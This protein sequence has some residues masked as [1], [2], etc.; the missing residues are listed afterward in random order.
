MNVNEIFKR[1]FFNSA[2]DVQGTAWRVLQ[3]HLVIE[4]NLDTEIE[5]F[6]PMGS[7]YLQRVS[8]SFKHKLELVAS[9][10]RIEE[11]LINA[12][13]EL[14]RVRNKVA[15]RF[16]YSIKLEDVDPIGTAFGQLI[17]KV[18]PNLLYADLKTYSGFSKSDLFQQVDTVL[19]EKFIVM[20]ELSEVD[21][22][23]TA[24]ERLLEFLLTRL[25]ILWGNAEEQL[26][27]QQSAQP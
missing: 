27:L 20:R 7:V 11:E 25:L 12:T 1:F 18:T 5:A 24:P 16:S 23:K 13:R 14:N 15:H 2:L 9:F 21:S 17:N 4:H 8:P 10:G 19:P 22:Q 3:G 6:L 26:T